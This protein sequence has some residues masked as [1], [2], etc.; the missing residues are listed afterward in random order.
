M[1]VQKGIVCSKGGKVEA[2]N[3]WIESLPPKS[4]NLVSTYV[5][6]PP[7]MRGIIV[8]SEFRRM[9]SDRDEKGMETAF[10]ENECGHFF[11]VDWREDDADIVAYCAESLGLQNL[12][13]EWSGSELVVDYNGARHVV[14]LLED[15][16]DR[17]VTLC[18]LNDILAPN[19]ELRFF[20]G[21]HGSDTGGFAALPTSDWQTLEREC[22][23]AVAENFLDP[24]KLPNV[25]TELT[26]DTLPIPARARFLRMLER[27]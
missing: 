9:L 26:E 3:A 19:Y 16:G 25:F 4:E 10:F 20:V 2:G 13:A 11:A 12:K 21:S 15:E 23:D 22:P 1:T 27:E 17:H 24:R 5:T 6:E 18:A 7:I 14:P 8:D